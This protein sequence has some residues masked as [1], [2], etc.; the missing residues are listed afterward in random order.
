MKILFVCLSIAMLVACKSEHFIHYTY[1]GITITRVDENECESYFYYG[2]FKEPKDLPK[3]CF[4][5]YYPGRDGTFEDYLIFSGGKKVT[6]LYYG[7]AIPK[8][9]GLDTLFQMKD[10]NSEQA[11]RFNDSLEAGTLKNAC[12]ASIY[13][14]ADS[15]TNKRHHSAI[16]V[17][18][19]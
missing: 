14:D 13:L 3:N 15:I 10:I 19:K 11:I 18:I 12:E 16:H 6:L 1:N 9:V 2:N 5:L 8:Q 7:G 17:D 4:Y